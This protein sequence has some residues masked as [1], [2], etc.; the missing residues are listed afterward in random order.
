MTRVNLPPCGKSISA[1]R[2]FGTHD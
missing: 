2:T 1:W